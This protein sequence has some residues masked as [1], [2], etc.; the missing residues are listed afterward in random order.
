MQSDTVLDDM[1]LRNIQKNKHFFL[2]TPLLFKKIGLTMK[3][4]EQSELDEF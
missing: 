3:F 2:G 4:E 1:Q